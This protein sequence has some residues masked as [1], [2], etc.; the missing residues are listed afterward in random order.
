M[1]RGLRKRTTSLKRVRKPTIRRKNSS[2][3]NQ[4]VPWETRSI[5]LLLCAAGCADIVAM[6]ALSPLIVMFTQTLSI[7]V[8]E[9][10]IAQLLYLVPQIFS[11]FVAERFAIRFGGIVLYSLALFA[12]S[13]S[14]FLST[15]AL[16]C[17]SVPMYLVSRTVAGLF[18]HSATVSAV[19]GH[20]YP[21]FSRCCDVKHFAPYF[22]GVA[23]ILGGVLG[24]WW[25]NI[26]AIS[27]VM[28]LVEFIT[29]VAVG[30][31]AFIF[32]RTPKTVPT[33]QRQSTLREWLLLQPGSKI[34]HLLPVA[35]LGFC[36]SIVQSLYPS[37]DRRVFNFSY[38]AVGAHMMVDTFM[39]IFVAPLVLRRYKGTPRVLVCLCSLLFF[40]SMWASSR[41]A[42]HGMGFYFVVSTLLT[43]LPAAVLQSAFTAY[44][45]NS[46]KEA[47][48]ELALKMQVCAR[49]IMKQWQPVL[50]MVIQMLLPDEKNVNQL[51][52]VPLA[53]GVM[54][55]VLSNRVDASMAAVAVGC[56]AFI[57]FSPI[58]DEEMME[59]LSSMLRWEFPTFLMG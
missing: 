8:F 33:A 20:Q 9:T 34:A 3:D 51:V 10:I 11:T 15:A 52:G 19:V 39:Q 57:I 55:F 45:T 16:H 58:D 53:L 42:K 59:N 27:G 6:A 30:V 44:T 5:A 2:E 23:V 40:L 4:V 49:K 37:V 29:A 41:F 38:L 46:F 22:L 36:A 14:A 1:E 35:L 13:V 28:A 26:A 7:T 24:D 54:M 47:E 12:T 50:F 25:P 31:V 56:A 48:R 32:A 43:D 18:R 21:E 17:K